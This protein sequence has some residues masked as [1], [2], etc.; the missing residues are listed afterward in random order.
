MTGDETPPILG[1]AN[2]A[3]RARPKKR[4]VK[5]YSG[6]LSG[7]GQADIEVEATADPAEAARSNL[8]PDAPPG[9][10]ARA[11]GIPEL[12]AEFAA[13]CWQSAALGIE[14]WTKLCAPAFESWLPTDR[15][16]L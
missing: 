15:R 7:V 8:A 11:V 6:S 13:L 12:Q 10:T 1:K 2:R 5:P 14:A 16:R 4:F 9:W 3:R